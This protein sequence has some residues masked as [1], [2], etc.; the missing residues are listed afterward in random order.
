VLLR[1][2]LKRRTH[3]AKATETAKAAARR[4]LFATKN[5][6]VLLLLL[7]AATVQV[8]NASVLHFATNTC[9]FLTER[10]T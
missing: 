2:E 4:V 6:P 1:F 5:S 7:P 9:H 8:A 3:S 10:S